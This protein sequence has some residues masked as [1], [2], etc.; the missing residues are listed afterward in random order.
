[1]SQRPALKS[2][3][4]FVKLW[5][6]QGVSSF[7][8]MF[9]ALALTALLYLHA[10][11][12][13][14]GLLAMAQ[15]LPA[16][17]F[18]LPAGALIDRLRRRPIL[19][20]ADLGRFVI[21]LSV[22]C[23]AALQ[24]LHMGQLYAVAF[25][26]GALEVWFRLAYRSYLPA[27]VSNDELLEANSRLSGTESVA[28]V[29]SP[30]AGGL[31]VQIAGG[32]VAVLI[33]A[34]TFLASGV[35]LA[36]IRTP[37]APPTSL[38]ASSMRMEIAEGLG[39]LWRNPTLRALAASGATFEFFGGFLSA[40]YGVYLIRTLHF[41]PFVMGLTIGAGGIG[42]I[43]GAIL[44]GRLTR[45][46]GLGRAILATRLLHDL[47]TFLIPLAGGPKL[48]AL[49]MI[50][51]AQ[52][53]GDP[54][55][56]SHDIATMSLRQTLVPLRLLGRVSSAMHLL[57]AVA[58]PLGAVVAGALAEAIGVRATLFLAAA[59][60]TSGVV[61]LIASPIPGMRDLQPVDSV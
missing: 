30:A 57:Q 55:W 6:G 14:L 29:G 49:A 38:P 22:P 1:M 13:Q 27:L 20:T 36:L 51:V 50:V 48:L 25:L 46:L 35:S 40:L 2:N 41:S 59:G 4:D 28:E 15:G 8:S 11:P 3:R 19:I 31:I 34:V 21:L 53:C 24:E 39:T 52:L 5:A 33:D 54:F 18:A 32:P 47:F 56:T 42:S 37:E 17:V 43:G 61:F 26:A 44:T 9:G 60:M 10:S 23:A 7:G 12:G 45:A 58:L 16:L